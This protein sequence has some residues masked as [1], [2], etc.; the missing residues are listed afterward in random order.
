MHMQR[1]FANIQ[2]ELADCYMRAKFYSS[3]EL[4]SMK[5]SSTRSVQRLKQCPPAL[6]K[7]ELGNGA[8]GCA[9]GRLAGHRAE[10][11]NA[12]AM[13]DDEQKLGDCGETRNARAERFKTLL[14]RS[15]MHKCRPRRT[16]GCG[17]DLIGIEKTRWRAS[18]GPV[19][20]AE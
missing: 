4:R 8:V 1:A 2:L 10:L 15:C 11:T 5:L 13:R 6:I 18:S 7:L 3:T 17:L 12:L 19:A 9:A 20:R 16:L 14:A